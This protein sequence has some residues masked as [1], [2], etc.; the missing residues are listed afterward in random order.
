MELN[1]F[2]LFHRTYV[3]VKPSIKADRNKVGIIDM[4]TH[5]YWFMTLEH[6]TSFKYQFCEI[7]SYASSESC[8]NHVFIDVCFGQYLKI[9]TCK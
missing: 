5:K 3:N 8:I 9:W 7:E 2:L 4:N 6:K 1:L